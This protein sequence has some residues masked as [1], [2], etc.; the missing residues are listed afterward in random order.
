M[1][2][3][4]KVFS[5]QG[6]SKGSIPA[7]AGPPST[8]RTKSVLASVYPRG[9]GAT[10]GRMGHDGTGRGL[11]PR[12]RGHRHLGAREAAFQRSIPADAGPPFSPTQH[13]SSLEVYPRGCGAT[14]ATPSRR[15]PMRGLSPRMRGHPEQATEQ[16]RKQRSIP[17]DAGPPQSFLGLAWWRRVYPRGCGATDANVS[18]GRCP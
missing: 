18:G 7:D 5:E 11:S 15:W 9:C 17:A 2:G 10:P 1:R 12:M 6:F 4:L 8:K 3:H 16:L 14:T 13:L